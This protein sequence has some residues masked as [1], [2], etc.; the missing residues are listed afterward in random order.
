M[1]SPR[2]LYFSNDG[3]GMTREIQQAVLKI[4]PNA[5]VIEAEWKKW[6]D[7]GNLSQNT[8]DFRVRMKTKAFRPDLLI[9][10]GMGG[11]W[12]YLLSDQLWIPAVLLNPVLSE[13][14]HPKVHNGAHVPNKIYCFG[15]MQKNYYDGSF[16]W[17]KK[18]RTFLPENNILFENVT[19]PD[20]PLMIREGM[21]LFLERVIG[22]PPKK[23]ETERAKEK[24]KLTELRAKEIAAKRNLQNKEKRD[25]W[26]SSL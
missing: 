7:V 9:G 16:R 14:V 10:E 22:V 3:K 13:N 19:K 5:V 8:S 23:T 21:K 4:S 24:K 11:R 25:I 15:G 20:Y 2:I 17:L 1:N 26:F 18:E 12:A 6:A